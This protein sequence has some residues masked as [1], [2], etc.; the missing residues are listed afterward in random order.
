M[1]KF[2]EASSV[3]VVGVSNSPT[4]LGRAIVYNMLRYQFPGVMYLVGPRGG[5]FM[6][7]R[8]Y[9]SVM[10]TPEPTDLA[11]LLIPA[12]AVPD[13]LVQC[14]EKGIKRVVVESGGFSELGDERRELEDKIRDILRRYGMRLIGPNCI[15]IINRWTGLAVP[16]MPIEPEAPP[17]HIGIISQ[18]GGVGG[19]ILN[20]LGAENLGYS[21]FA[22]IGNKLNTDECDIL[23][24]YLSDDR[25]RVIFCYLEGINDGRRLMELAS[26]HDKPV[27]LFKS[28]C[29][30]ASRN[31][32]RSHSASLA[33]DDSV[34]SAACRQAGII[35]VESQQEAI[36]ALKG[37]SLPPVKGNRLAVISRSGGHA[38][39]AADAA[40]EF[41]FELPPF[42]DKLIRAVEE[43]SRAG[44]IRFQN[45]LDLGDVFDFDLY[46]NLARESAGNPDFDCLLFVHHYQGLFDRESSRKLIEAI[47]QVVSE[48]GKPIALCVFTPYRELLHNK[49]SV[50]FPIFTD[51]REA[52]KVL[53]LSRD[54]YTLRP[55]ALGSA[56]SAVE[57]SEEARLILQGSP[58]GVMHP[59]DAG[60]FLKACGLPLVPWKKATDEEEA[61]EKAGE[62]GFPVVLKTANPA[63][64][65]KT[66]AGG[67]FL[68]IESEKD[69]RKAY[70]ELSRLGP[71]VIVQKMV[72]SQG[73]EWIVGGKKDPNFGPVIITGSGGI[74]VEVFKDVSMRVAPVG[75]EEAERMILETKGASLLREFR[76]RRAMNIDALTDLVVRTSQIL[77]AFPRI[78]ELDLNPVMVTPEGI[79]V[80]DWRIFLAE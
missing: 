76:G 10:E 43:K 60:T 65:H 78:A 55:E 72:P 57:F 36:E 70:G 59:F 16:F 56:V 31:I 68:G 61:A 50:K 34:V 8:I 48:T 19:S 45:P 51:P 3:T 39:I 11:V 54:F 18:S 2:F 20:S 73:V 38:V 67:V 21:L 6:G 79:S 77:Y 33:A 7:F 5:S 69:L 37:F 64:V 30:E 44:V 41:G 17:G 15:G 74:I 9:R 63:I 52:V 27:I 42:P 23:E 47:P 13:V 75:K 24:H 14:G 53:A 28:N 71:E 1:K 62:I 40:G 49:Q 29:N 4:N 58:A 80:L 12:R 22:S 46:L 66:D 32:A 26:T 35:R 25:T